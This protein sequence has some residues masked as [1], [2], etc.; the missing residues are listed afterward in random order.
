L[1]AAFHIKARPSQSLQIVLIGNTSASRS[2]WAPSL[3]S[4]S[5][6]LQKDGV[7]DVTCYDV[8][9]KLSDTGWGAYAPL[10]LPR[11]EEK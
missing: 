8:Y 1:H 7:S 9:V 3:T 5:L 10:S 11:Q 6:G 2:T 4:S